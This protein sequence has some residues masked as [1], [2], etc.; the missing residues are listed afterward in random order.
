MNRHCYLLFKNRASLLTITYAVGKNFN[1]VCLSV[2][3][4]VEMIGRKYKKFKDMTKD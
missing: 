1:Q 2:C 4:S 3:L